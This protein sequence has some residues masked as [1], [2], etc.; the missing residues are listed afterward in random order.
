MEG[1][2]IK[3]RRLRSATAVIE[4]WNGTASS[5]LT[6]TATI[7]IAGDTV[8]SSAHRFNHLSRRI[9]D[10]FVPEGFPSS[11]TPDYVPF[12]IWDSLQ[13]L[14]T[15]MRMMLS[16]Q[17]LL[18]AIGVGE[19]SATVIGATFQWFLRDL[20][21]MLGGILFTFYQGSNLDSNAKMW[22]LVADLMNDLGMLMDLLSPLFPSAFVFIVCLG[23]ISRS[24]T[25]VTSGA[26]RAALTQ[27]FALQNNA[28]DISAKE[29]SQET[30]ATMIGM[31]LGMLLARITMGHSLAIWFCFLSLTFFHM[32]ANYKAVRCLSLATLN[33]ERSSIVLLRYMETGQVLS[34][35]QVSEMEH[36]LPTWMTSWTENRV[37]YMHQRVRL[38]VRIS[39]LT[40]DEVVDLSTL[41]SSYY[42]K[43]K[44]I[45]LPRKGTV[46]IIM[47]KDSTAADVLQ[48]FMHALV[49]A[50]LIDKDGSVHSESQSWI[51]KNYEDFVIKLQSQGWR[52]ERLLSPSV[53]W[54]A[55]WFTSSSD[56]KDD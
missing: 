2:N 37:N 25:G 50:I 49:L 53:A 45:P 44:Y 41:S 6:K 15:Y 4:E 12:Q 47:H 48:A 17:A 55:N 5:K 43:G 11:V 26:T 42:N 52:T 20:T 27:H 35:N 21:G 19:K 33:C 14:S 54:K 7:T 8:R 23:S 24:F 31:A 9:L 1:E 51:A 56:E 29:G 30:L 32:Y 38:G 34:P 16:T 39:S 18:S 22:R 13:G 3:T 46:I 10:A 28:A 40:S 36:V